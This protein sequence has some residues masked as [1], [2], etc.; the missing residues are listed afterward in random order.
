MSDDGLRGVRCSSNTPDRLAS[1]SGLLET[2]QPLH[3]AAAGSTDT[4]LQD[5]AD[6]FIRYRVW[7][8]PPHRPGGQND[9]EQVRAVA[10][11]EHGVLVIG[12][13]EVVR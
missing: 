11:I 7:F 3:V 4:R 6:E 10:F 9:L 8:Q 2:R 5:L 1:D 12:S 13:A